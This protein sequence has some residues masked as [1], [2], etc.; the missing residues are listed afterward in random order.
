M[1]LS[2]HIRTPTPFLSCPLLLCFYSSFF[3]FLQSS[4]RPF[5]LLPDATA[6]VVF[7]PASSSSS[8]YCN[9]FCFF[10][11]LLV[12]LPIKLVYLISIFDL[13]CWKLFGS[14]F[15]NWCKQ[16]AW[17]FPIWKDEKYKL[18]FTLRKVKVCSAGIWMFI[19]LSR[20]N[21]RQSFSDKAL[22]LTHNTGLLL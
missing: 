5:I 8:F 13:F 12:A 18:T 21:S 6:I 22:P 7:T 16:E 11:F 1:S 2:P 9:V 4:R 3:S 10:I 15:G 17:L 19:W 20:T 14:L